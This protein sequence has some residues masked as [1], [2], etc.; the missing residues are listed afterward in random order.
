MWVLPNKDSFDACLND[1]K[2]K[3]Y[4]DKFLQSMYGAFIGTTKVDN[5]IK[6]I[7]YKN[8]KYMTEY[9]GLEGWR[10]FVDKMLLEYYVNE[11]KEPRD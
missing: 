5:N 11:N 1:S 9:Q 6:A 8:R 4:V 3:G 10:R 7:L 2:Y